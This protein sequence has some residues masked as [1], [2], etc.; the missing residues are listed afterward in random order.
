MEEELEADMRAR[1]KV[2]K[3]KTQAEEELQRQILSHQTAFQ[4]I[5]VLLL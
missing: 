4:A 5:K 1:E 3:E 2:T